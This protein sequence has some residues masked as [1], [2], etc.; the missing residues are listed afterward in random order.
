M[1]SV[2]LSPQAVRRRTGFRVLCV[3]WL[4]DIRRPPST[5]TGGLLHGERCVE[6]SVPLP[7]L[8]FSLA[9]SLISPHSVLK[10]CTMT[11]TVEDGFF[12]SLSKWSPWQELR[13]TPV[14]PAVPSVHG[15]SR[16]SRKEKRPSNSGLERGLVFVWPLME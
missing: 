9:F 1:T 4:P 16:R 8:C 7:E 5:G 11:N 3:A 6:G 15:G 2:P 10:T 14:S 12:D 13:D